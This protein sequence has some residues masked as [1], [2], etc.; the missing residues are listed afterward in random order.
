MEPIEG[1]NALE[2]GL[3]VLEQ[4]NDPELVEAYRAYM[5]RLEELVGH[6]YLDTYALVY[7]RERRQL[8]GQA[9]G[10][11]ISPAEQAV[12]DTVAADPQVHALYDQYIAL[13]KAHGIADPEFDSAD[14]Q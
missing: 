13:A 4:Y 11:T 12:R 3:H 7:Q 2:Q 1:Q 8:Y 10:A 6:E 9:A 14:Q 5:Q